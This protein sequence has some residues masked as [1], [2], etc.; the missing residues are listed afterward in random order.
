MRRFKE[1]EQED[2]D[3]RMAVDGFM[4]L[5][6]KISKGGEKKACLGGTNTE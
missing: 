3:I 2:D 6:S 4:F 1:N 5:A